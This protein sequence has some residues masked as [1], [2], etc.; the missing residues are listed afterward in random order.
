MHVHGS[1]SN[2]PRG[3]GEPS[4]RREVG[5]RA[6]GGTRRLAIAGSLALLLAGGCADERGGAHEEPRDDAM[7]GPAGD[8]T[9]GPAGDA[10]GDAAGGPAGDA[11]GGPT[12]DAA[13]DAAGGLSIVVEPPAA[14]EGDGS[15]L[16]SPKA[17]TVFVEDTVELVVVARDTIG[18]PPAVSIVD[19]PPGSE[20]LARG[21][22]RHLFRWR[23]SRL[24]AGTLDVVFEA[25]REDDPDVRRSADVHLDVLPV[26]KESRFG[27]GPPLR[28]LA[29][30]HGVHL[31]FAALHEMF[32]IEEA[33]LYAAIATEEYDILT[34]ENSMKMTHLRPA[35]G[36][37]EWEASDRIVEFAEANDML[38]HGHPLVWGGQHPKWIRELESEAFPELMR[39]HVTALVSRYR[40]RVHVWDVVNE[41]FLNTGRFRQSRWYLNVGERFFTDAFHLARELD[42]APALIYNDY[43]IGWLNPKSDALLEHLARE[44]ELGTPI[45]GV[46]FQLHLDTDFEPGFDSL[47]E[48]FRRF[49]E[50]GLD[51]YITEMDIAVDWHGDPAVEAERQADVY[52]GVLRTCIE[53]PRCRAMQTWGLGDRHAWRESQKV[54]PFDV[55]YDAKPAYHAMRRVL[56][57]TPATPRAPD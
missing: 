25:T 23:P 30:V 13:G 16:D 46:G 22:G 57:E 20:F 24:D 27:Q 48:N 17:R 12:G 47:R 10:A 39:E 36:V 21:D 11:A 55:N 49:A 40:G 15:S 38:V 35:P 1:R 54:M 44:L 42:P 8:V 19:P 56:R 31:G 3:T 50:L 41:A 29:V 53:Q 4:E 45:D 32:D 9:D 18:S 14:G 43:G 26:P 5:R 6:R 28:D 37:F 7:D 51:I 52:A 2:S 33:D 34:P